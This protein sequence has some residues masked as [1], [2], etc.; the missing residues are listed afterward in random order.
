MVPLLAML[1][2]R[3]R[4]F[5]LAAAAVCFLLLGFALY[6]QHFLN[7]KPCPLC[8]FQRIAVIALGVAFILAALVPRGRVAGVLASLLIGGVALSGAIVAGGHL[9]L[10]MQSHAA[11]AVATCG[12]PLAHLWE[13]N[14]TGEFLTK[15]FKGTGDCS[16]TNWIFL[17]IPMP[18][19]VLIWVL[20][21]GIAGMLVNWP[22]RQPRR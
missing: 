2:S 1:R 4:A 22:E 20:A 3:R 15:V 9:R 16:E 14:P 19:W 7:F 10:Q 5:N 17:G 21:L 8:I 6:S 11:G 18:G 13:I 12:A